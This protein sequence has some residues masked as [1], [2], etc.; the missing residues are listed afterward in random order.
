MSQLVTEG[1]ITLFQLDTRPLGGP[2][3]YFTSAEDLTTQILWG[4]ELYV[5]LPMEA[6][7]F[8]M[9][10]RGAIPTPTIMISNLYGAGNLLLSTYKGLL[11]AKIIRI[12][13]LRRFLDDGSSPDA[14]AYITRDVYV[15]SQKTT[16][17]AVAIA[18]KLASAMDHE[19]TLL[20]RRLILRDICTHVYRI[21]NPAIGAFDYSKASCPYAG[22]WFSDANNTPG[23]PQ[24]DQCSRT[25][26]GCSQRFG[27]QVLPARFF[28]GVGRVK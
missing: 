28:P 19:G 17:N 4:G 2:I 8:E 22:N 7:G 1:V 6:S 14:N 26:V 27:G 24:Q 5:A 16:H 10:T 20:P 15:V 12:L 23:A 13:T 11:G 25:I 21:W 18:F 3:H 9:T